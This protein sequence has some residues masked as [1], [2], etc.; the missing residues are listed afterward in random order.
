[1]EY[2]LKIKV[3]NDNGNSEHDLVIDG[4]QIQQSNVI[5]KVRKAPNVEELNNKLFISKIENNLIVDIIS[6]KVKTGTYLCGNYAIKSGET[7]RTIAIGYDNDKSNN[8]IV[9]INTLAQIGGYAVKQAFNEGKIEEDKD[10]RIKVSV[11]MTTALPI[12]Q[13]NKTK[14]HEFANKFTE[15]K[16]FVNVVT[17]NKKIP[18]EIEFDFVKVIPEGITTVFA[19]TNADESLFREHNK[20][21]D[22]FYSIEEN[23]QYSDV[24][25]KLNKEYFED[26]R[27]LH[28]AIGEGTTECPITEGRVFNP[29]F[30]RGFNNGVG[31]SINKSLDEFKADCGQTNMSRQKYSEILKDEKHKFH[32]LAKEIIEIPLEEQA[33]EIFEK[34]KNEIDRANNEVDI[35]VVYGGG[36]IL[37]RESLERK[38]R[39][40]CKIAKINLFYVNKEYAVILESVG[41]F[42]FTCSSIFNQVK[43]INKSK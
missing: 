26:K 19:L 20:F 36:S 14:A 4:T 7:V 2:N 33:E 24:Y 38:L 11:D 3:R 34:A 10:I 42:N 35:I 37:M 6:D 13:Y 32:G 40:I 43:K 17:P 22:K 29:N 5:S 25:V 15:D 8:E 27:I 28:I 31:H 21:V 41:L 12:S 1:M 23:K 30:I 39:E 18:V 9:M 16:H